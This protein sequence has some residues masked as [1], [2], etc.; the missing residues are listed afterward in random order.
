MRTPILIAALVALFAAAAFAQAG[1]PAE[2]PARPLT[3]LT[4]QQQSLNRLTVL[5]IITLILFLIM[6]FTVIVF[7]MIL[8]RRVRAVEERKEKAATEL[9]DLWWKMGMPEDGQDRTDK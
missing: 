6:I 7:G 5:F 3:Q 4:P 8:H 9:E 2:A 1:L